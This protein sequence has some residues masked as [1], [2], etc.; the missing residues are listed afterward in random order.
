M[1]KYNDINVICGNYNL[2]E[3][4]LRDRYKDDPRVH[5]FSHVTDIWR[6]YEQADIAISAGGS[7]LYEL[8][9]MGV[10]TITYSFADNQIPNVTY[11][12]R[13]GLM[14]C[15]GDVRKGNVPTGVCRSL[16]EMAGQDH[17]SDIS[18]RLQELVDGKG[19]ARLASL[20]IE[21]N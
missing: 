14:P 20:I 11:F 21:D 17:R 7:T 13:Y 3:A 9:S 15:A 2:G 16:E 19:A 12:D 4:E 6:L 18:K 8:A 5:I 1:E 10:P